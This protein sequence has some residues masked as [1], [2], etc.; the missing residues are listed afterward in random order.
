[1]I[2]NEYDF[3]SHTIDEVLILL[4]RKRNIQIDSSE[5]IEIA[6]CNR[7]EPQRFKSLLSNMI[8]AELI[9]MTEVLVIDKN[10]NCSLT[11]WTFSATKKARDFVKQIRKQFH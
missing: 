6:R 2:Y 11:S 10:T 4:T 7:I 3:L 9:E 8:D 5:L 1:M